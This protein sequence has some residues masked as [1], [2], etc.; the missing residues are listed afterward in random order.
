MYEIRVITKTS[1]IHLATKIK[2]TVKKRN[3]SGHRV[4]E[5]TGAHKMSTLWGKPLE[6]KT[7]TKYPPSMN[8]Q[9]P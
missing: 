7:T 4:A 8:R 1:M 2:M 6:A 3:L 5:V 9:V